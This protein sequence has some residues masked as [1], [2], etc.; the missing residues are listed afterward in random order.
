ME[1]AWYDRLMSYGLMGTAKQNWPLKPSYHMM[2]LFTSS[3]KAGWRAIKIDGER[4][5]ACVASLTDGKE[6]TIYALNSSLKRL[7]ISI[8]GMNPKT[9]FDCLTWNKSGDGTLARDPKLQ[10]D[11]AGAV[12]LQLPPLGVVA[13]TTASLEGKV[14]R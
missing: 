3:S 5:G 13:I 8:E 6:L 9:T 12:T 11:A 7:K 4:E 10:S 2:R 1:D 14:S